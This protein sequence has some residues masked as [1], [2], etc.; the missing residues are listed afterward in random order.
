MKR[1]LVTGGS[2]FLGI[3]CIRHLLAHNY[4]ITSLDLVPF[5]YPEKAQI[6]EIQGDIRDQQAVQYGK[7]F[8]SILFTLLF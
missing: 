5:D 4:L 6:T 1:V 7:W 2:G 3:N 8:G